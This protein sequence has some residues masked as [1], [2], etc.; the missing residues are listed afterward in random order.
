MS[1]IVAQVAH[2]LVNPRKSSYV[3]LTNIT[4]LAPLSKAR[5]VLSGLERRR[6]PCTGRRLLHLNPPSFEPAEEHLAE[7]FSVVFQRPLNG[8]DG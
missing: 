6:S 8:D 1:T 3:R 5:C 7:A 4:P 2:L